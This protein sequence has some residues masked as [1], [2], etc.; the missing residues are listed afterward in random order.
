MPDSET[1]P[2]VALL[3]FELRQAF[4]RRHGVALMSMAAMGFV[5]AFW[6]PMFPE[7]V[8][9]FFQRVFQ[10]DNWAQIVVA[11]DLDGP[12]VLHL[13]DRRLRC[14]DDLCRT[15]GGATA[16]PLSVEAALAS[17]VHGGSARARA[18]NEHWHLY[19]IRRGVLADA[20]DGA[21]SVSSGSI[22]RCR[23]RS[24]G[25]DADPRRHRES[26]RA[27]DARI[28]CGASLR[29]HPDGARDPAKHVLH[30]ST[31]HFHR[32]AKGSR[33]DRLPL[34]LGLVS[35]F[36]RQLGIGDCDAIASPRGRPCRP[37]ADGSSS[38]ATWAE[39]R[40][41]SCW[42]GGA[43]CELLLEQL[44]DSSVPLGAFLK[45][46]FARRPIWY[47]ALAVYR[48]SMRYATP[49]ALLHGVKNCKVLH[50]RTCF[51]P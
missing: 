37:S 4:R 14:A 11:N 18:S 34:E 5:L 6:L 1:S 35:R 16:G 29:I 49:R 41:R 36:C 3:R 22:H 8:F 19:G 17:R 31:R 26:C 39:R 44:H 46:L 10:L 25:L 7:S 24:A 23:G 51:S 40:S 2:F 15:P 13:L 21:A 30:V 27:L 32:C 9:R 12:L 28:V 38:G 42:R 50:E 48:T 47:R 45:S 20:R 43:G 33:S